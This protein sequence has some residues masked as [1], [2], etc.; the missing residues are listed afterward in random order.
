MPTSKSAASGIGAVG[1]FKTSAVDE[2]TLSVAAKAEGA[3]TT[4]IKSVDASSK[5]ANTAL[6]VT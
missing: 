6:P 1:V 5:A 3:A 4:A 2:V